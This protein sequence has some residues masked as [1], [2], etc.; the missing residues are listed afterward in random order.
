L[1]Q[2]FCCHLAW[3]TWVLILLSSL[4]YLLHP[5]D[6]LFSS[7]TQLPLFFLPSSLPHIP[8]ALLPTWPSLSIS[9]PLTFF[10]H[11]E[12]NH[13]LLFSFRDNVCTDSRELFIAFRSF[14]PAYFMVSGFLFFSLF[15][16]TNL[17]AFC[18]L[19]HSLIS[20]FTFPYTF[21]PPF[22]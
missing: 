15:Y 19:L 14:W 11:I 5:T 21:S 7:F 20:L 2:A 16:P 4:S 9:P 6:Y 18:L 12:D 10:S 22:I 17:H 3:L 8:F 1:F 13:I